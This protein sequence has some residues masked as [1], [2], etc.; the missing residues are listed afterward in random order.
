MLKATRHEAVPK[1]YK[2]SHFRDLAIELG[3]K[4]TVEIPLG[5]R[6]LE[7]P[8][9]LGENDI[10]EEL[11]QEYDQLIQEHRQAFIQGG[12]E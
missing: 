4:A 10:R 11:N 7:E 9:S 8:C 12:F 1:G 6:T 3:K 5:Q 2:K